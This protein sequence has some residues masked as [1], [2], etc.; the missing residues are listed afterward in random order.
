MTLVCHACWTTGSGEEISDW[1]SIEPIVAVFRPKSFLLCFHVF[2]DKIF[3][4]LLSKSKVQ[5][6]CFHFQLFELV[7][8]TKFGKAIDAFQPSQFCVLENKKPTTNGSLCSIWA[9]A[10]SA[11]YIELFKWPNFL[12]S[13]LIAACVLLLLGY[14]VTVFR[15]WWSSNHRSYWRGGSMSLR[16]HFS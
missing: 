2:S 12:N 1:V 7:Y 3:Q 14:F 4:F 16:R 5:I 15:L 9:L 8:N 13:S 10:C 6:F 11:S